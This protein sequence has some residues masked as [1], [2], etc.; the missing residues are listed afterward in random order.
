M[1]PDIETIVVGAGVVG[2]AIAR[3]TASIGHETLLIERNERIGAETSSRNSE[4]IH[5]GIYYPPGSLRA[6]MCVKGRDM[7]YRFAAENG[8]S[9][10]R[11]GKLI[12]ATLP[13]DLP[14]LQTILERAQAAG[15]HDL[16]Q[17]DEQAAKDLEPELNCIAALLSPSTGVIDTHELMTALDGHLTS[18]GGQ[19]V[20]STNVVSIDIHPDGLFALTTRSTATDGQDHETA[21]ITCRNLILS[22]GLGA[23]ELARNVK[24]SWKQGY[25]P[26]QVHPA[27]GHYFTLSQRAPFN[28]LI[29]PAPSGAWLGIHLTL[30]IAGQAKF[31]PDLQWIDTIDYRFD[32]PD[33]VRR[34]TFEREVRRYWPG[35][36]TGKLE[37]GYTG[38]RPK[39]YAQGE[40]AADFA[41]HGPKTH[42]IEN[43]IALYGIESPGL[44]SSLALAEHVAGLIAAKA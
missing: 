32:D 6:K 37:Q 35:L 30:D 27:K 14:Q 39:I 24:P 8:V 4:V 16:K 11:L 34:K 15:V 12:V 25:Q 22:A 5:A 41:I 18:L 20:L 7:L 1:S 10:N 17:L 33:G 31:G 3:A 21:T 43:L 42:G 2:L 19:I 44:T 29:Y 28:H 38:I 23:T 9:V 36:P 26:P 40:P 13:D